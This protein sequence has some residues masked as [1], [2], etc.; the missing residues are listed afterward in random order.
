MEIVFEVAQQ[1][2]GKRPAVLGALLEAVSEVFPLV[3]SQAGSALSVAPLTNKSTDFLL[4]S[5][6]I[7]Q[8]DFWFLEVFLADDAPARASK[9]RQ[10]WIP[11]TQNDSW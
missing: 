3:A 11:Y 1:L 7:S 2:L 10:R 9:N 5:S 8:I 4:R 6:K